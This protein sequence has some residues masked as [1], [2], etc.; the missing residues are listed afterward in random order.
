[1]GCKQVINLSALKGNIPESVYEEL[2][3]T[4][5]RFNLNSP[6]RIAHF[7]AQCHHESMGF[8]RKEENL[9]YSAE[10]LLQVFPKYFNPDQAKLYARN[11]VIIA[12]R[13]YAN[14]MGNREEDSGDGYRYRGRGYI[15]LTGHD[16]YKAFDLAVSDDVV[17]N[18]DFVAMKYPLFS[19]GWFWNS[20]R[21]NDL[22][23]LGADQQVVADI[24][25]KINGGYHGLEDRVNQFNKFYGLVK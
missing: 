23:D 15:Q 22:A 21:L 6:L 9:N 20:R 2:F 10:R 7:L 25:K 5:T 13:V 16:N 24:T 11:P 4:A 1:M 12:S 17:G 18:P 3:D 8:S 19:A 14:R